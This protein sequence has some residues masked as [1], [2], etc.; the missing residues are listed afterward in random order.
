MNKILVAL[1]ITFVSIQV[2][3]QSKVFK[4][5]TDDISSN[6]QPITQDGALMGYLAFTRLEQVSEDSFHY[7][8]TIMDENLNDIGVVP[9]TNEK[10]E[11][12]AVSFE[13]DVL[14]LAYLKSNLINTEF[15]NRKS[16]K[17]ALAKSDP[18][19]VL[20]FLSLDGKILQESSMKVTPVN[21]E[22]IY[23]S[24]GKFQVEVKLKHPI[25]LAN[26]PQKGFACS[27][28]DETTNTL[29]AYSTSGQKIW[30][31]NTTD[32][33][34]FVL[35][36]TAED[37]FML[38]KQKNDYPEGGY[39]LTVYGVNEG[40]K[41]LSY[42]L[43]D[44]NQAPLKVLSFGKDLTTGKP[45]ISGNIIN[46][47]RGKKYLTGKNLATGAYAG[48]FTLNFNGH[49]KTDVK[50]TFSYWLDGS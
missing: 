9:F 46:A 13:Q 26:I 3:A 43:K 15:S 42:E 19:I 6:L 31:K 22:K 38:S 41:H 40:S 5:V 12:Q 29:L 50:E 47:D 4:E 18:A 17:K 36:T 8:I 11:L 32:S 34:G 20:Q 14:C 10:M 44:R 28:G 27:Y 21:S 1:C 45:F 37:I 25:Q 16:Y 23:S 35:V 49:S 39:S 7:K 2:T 24:F 30:K 48:V 33:E